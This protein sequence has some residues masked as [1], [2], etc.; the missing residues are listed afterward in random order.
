MPHCSRVLIVLFAAIAFM[1]PMSAHAAQYTVGPGHYGSIQAAINVASENDTI[2]VTHGTWTGNGNAYVNPIDVDIVIRSVAGPESTIIDGQHI[3]GPVF[4]FRGTHL[5]YH[6]RI[7][8]LTFTNCWNGLGGCVVT[9]AEGADPI[10]SDCIFLE[11][12]NPAN[13]GAVSV[14]GSFS[15]A[16][17]RFEHCIFRGNAAEQRGG[18]VYARYGTETTFNYCLFDENTQEDPSH[19]GG[20]VYIY[21]AYTVFDHCTFVE[22]G[23]SQIYAGGST[24]LAT[25]T[26]CIFAD[27]PTG[28]AFAIE[29][30]TTVYVNYAMVY[31][32]AG[33]NAVPCMH[34]HVEYDEPL[35]CDAS[36]DDY[37]LC[38]NSPCNAAN[39][40]WGR[41]FGCR[42]EGCG[43][44]DSP[45]ESTSWGRLK[46]L[47]RN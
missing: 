18:A 39:N 26:D 9:V 34:D 38:M 23:R 5:T 3:Y 47:F 24:G 17:P 33:G 25:F 19:G 32:N 10:F 30:S 44:C 21:E 45:V 27:S 42:M 41:W 22:N 6:S 1:L 12:G 28:P 13:G 35:F 8:G 2:L 7:E 20:A 40:T 4:D 11:N 46:S 16:A 43:D 29:D 31:G 37:T 36:A 15:G 14:N